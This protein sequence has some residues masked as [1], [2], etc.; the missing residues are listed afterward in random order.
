MSD[1]DIRESKET[2]L[3]DIEKKL[4]FKDEQLRFGQQV[5]GVINITKMGFVVYS[6]NSRPRPCFCGIDRHS[7]VI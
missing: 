2:L 7:S 5:C 4:Q 1:D 6:T 3:Q